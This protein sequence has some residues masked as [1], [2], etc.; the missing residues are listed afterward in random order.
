MLDSTETE[1][2]TGKEDEVDEKDTINPTK[3]PLPR[4][5]IFMLSAAL[6]FVG[7]SYAINDGFGVPLLLEAG[8]KGQYAPFVL[9]ISS[10]INV[11]LGGYLGSSSDR[12]TNPFGRRRPY[13]IGLATLLLIAAILYPYGK[14]LSHVFQ[15]K[16]SSRTIHLIFHTAICVITFDVCLD[17][18]NALDRSYLFDSITVQ[19]NSYGNAIFSL[20]TSAGSCFGALLSA[21]NWEDILHLSNGGQTK[22]VFA[23]VIIILL[24]CV[25]LTINSVKE[26]KIGK[27][28]KIDATKNSAWTR[29]F[30]SCNY[31]AFDPYNM[32]MGTKV[33]EISQ[34]EENLPIIDFEDSFDDELNKPEPIPHKGTVP[35]NRISC[36]SKCYHFIREAFYTIYNAL[37]FIKSL[38][39]ATL[40]LWLAQV[41]EWMTM[42]S[43]LF[44]ITNFVASIVYNGLPN[45]EPNSKERKDYDKGVRMGFLCQCIGYGSSLLFSLFL[46]SKYSRK[47]ET[48]AIYV[49]IHVLTFLATGLL[50]FSKSIYLVASLHI[51]FGCFYSWIQIVPF[52]LLQKYKV[53]IVS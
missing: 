15:L 14:V 33:N 4:G 6:F 13:I 16:H 20:M 3:K 44:F 43:L 52:N 37:C 39:T 10:T 11:F 32:Y 19:Q 48:R 35:Q 9:G 45:A 2:A 17:M 7:Y 21:L 23:T 47:I 18:T 38:S 12:C 49:G 5:R 26:P 22:I 1:L 31:F 50:I 42:L 51:I 8:I 28:G 30:M 53:F 40:C 24:V 27:N 46:Y 25:M 34:S 41:L 29:C 36:K